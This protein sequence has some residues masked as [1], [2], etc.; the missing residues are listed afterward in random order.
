[1]QVCVYT[2]IKNYFPIDIL[3]HFITQIYQKQKNH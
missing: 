1:M 3:I 2:N